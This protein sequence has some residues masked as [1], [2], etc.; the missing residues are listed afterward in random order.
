[1]TAPVYMKP[2]IIYIYNY[3]IIYIH[4]LSAVLYLTSVTP[5]FGNGRVNVPVVLGGWFSGARSINACVSMCACMNSQWRSY[6]TNR[7]D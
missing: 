1:M 3:I 4:I 5:P 6:T 7:G 2:E